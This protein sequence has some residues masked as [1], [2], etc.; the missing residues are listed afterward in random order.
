[1]RTKMHVVLF[2]ITKCLVPTLYMYMENVDINIRV[3]L[4][5]INVRYLRQHLRNI[6]H[7]IVEG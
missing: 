2:H 1:M 5:H 3:K 7:F 6:C 4:V